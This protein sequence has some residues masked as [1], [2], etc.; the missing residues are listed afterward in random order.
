MKRM[1]GKKKEANEEDNHA[2]HLERWPE[3]RKSFGFFL[4]RFKY[5][6]EKVGPTCGGAGSA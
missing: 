2:K 3:Y 5:I 4:W 6:F 1:G